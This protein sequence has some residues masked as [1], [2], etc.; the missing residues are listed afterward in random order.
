[1]ALNRPIQVLLVES[2]PSFRQDLI[3][4]I[5]ASLQHLHVRE[6]DSA[7][8]ALA[9]LGED[10]TDILITDVTLPGITGIELVMRLRLS[11]NLLPAVLISTEDDAKIRRIGGMIGAPNVITRATAFHTIPSVLLQILASSPAL[12]RQH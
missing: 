11:G 8:T 3:A 9:M 5:H 12:Q 2:Q 6:A 10:N 1:M 7:E 4:A